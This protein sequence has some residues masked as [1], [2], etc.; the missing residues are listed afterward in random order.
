MSNGGPVHETSQPTPTSAQ[1]GAHSPRRTV[2]V[3]GGIAGL[4]AAWEATGLGDN[5]ELFE[6]SD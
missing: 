6:A 5:V 1:P 4:A 2:V 3:G